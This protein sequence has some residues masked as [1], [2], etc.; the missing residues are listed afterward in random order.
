VAALAI[1]PPTTKLALA[2]ANDRKW[3]AP[4]IDDSRALRGTG[5][6]PV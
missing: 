2:V 1:T 5:S 3:E 4:W 6:E